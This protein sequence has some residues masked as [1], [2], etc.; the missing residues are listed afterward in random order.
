MM[1]SLEI[2]GPF[3][4]VL[5]ACLLLA[6]CTTPRKG[7][8]D[9]PAVTPPVVERP[10]PPNDIS[11]DDDKASP[12]PPAETEQHEEAE[13]P[14]QRPAKLN[15]YKVVLLLPFMTNRFDRTEARFNQISEW[16][17][18][19]Y[20]GLKL[21]LDKLRSQ[22]TGFQVEILDTRGSEN[23]IDRLLAG[24]AIQDAHLIIGP[25]RR[26]NIQKVADY[27]KEQGITMVSPYSAAA[28]LVDAHPNFIQVRPSLETHCNSLLQH[29]LQTHSPA[30]I[31]L[32][33]QD[34]PL[35][36]KSFEYFQEAHFRL[37]GTRYVR[38]LDEYLVE[39]DNEA[40]QEMEVGPLLAGRDTA[41]FMLSAWSGD[42]ENFVYSFLRLLEL[43]RKAG[44][45]IV[46]YGTPV[47]LDY[48][49]IDLDYFEKLN[50][51]LSSHVFID[52][53]DPDV[54]EFRR[55]Y[56][57]RF[58]TLPGEE[59]FLGYD[60]MLYFGR[61]LSKFGRGFEDNLEKEEREGLHTRFHFERVVDAPLTTG[62]ENQPIQLYE[63][64][65]VNILK[66]DNYQFVLDR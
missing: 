52:S 2:K 9:R 51:H 37:A 1:N 57:D 32:V 31:V 34:S 60:T 28:N 24:E 48:D 13:S 61:M 65:Y 42:D 18:H 29:A 62:E 49:R 64:K 30:S 22:D 5:I 33:G 58:A 26:A 7:P 25:Y 63:N 3:T 66:F 46:V 41:V 14:D 11:G 16:S 20:G 45:H 4:F 21:A 50:V 27:A 40:Y 38:K 36:K 19:Y 56:F 10:T 47:W 53:A 23:S 15:S 54:R 39:D 17:L 43:N 55:D 44:Q 35:E 59:A 8:G 12:L 6:G